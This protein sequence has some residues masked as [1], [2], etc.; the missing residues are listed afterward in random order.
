MSLRTSTVGSFPKPKSLVRARRLFAEGEIDAAALEE[1]GDAA[2]REVLALQESLGL[3]LL[4]DGE[5]DR[6]DMTTFFAERVSGMEVSGLVRS[7]GNRYYRKPVIRGDVRRDGPMT[8]ERFRFASGIAKR[9][10]KAILT[11]P[12]TLMDWS[13]DEHYP[14]R[15]AA[16]MALAEVV[17]EEVLDLAKA[18]AAEIQID[19]PA[20]SARPDE[21][22]LAAKALDRVTSAVRGKA[23]TWAHVCYGEFGPVLEAM[24]RLPVDGL[25]LEL[26]NSGYD[27]IEAIGRLLPRDKI[28]GA[29]VVDSHSHEVEPVAVVRARIERVLEAVPPERVFLNPDC[30]LKTRTLEEARGKLEA[31]VAAA[32]EVSAARGLT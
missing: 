12:Y 26:A 23:R 17:R 22:A 6:G 15:E 1:A 10:V 20:V 25:L 4:V 24:L 28:L 27:T 19:E 8:V 21:I 18:G 30:G 29:G 31:M 5:M 32:R 11:G 14:S 3:D 7:Y 9:P 2:T 13:F 16:A